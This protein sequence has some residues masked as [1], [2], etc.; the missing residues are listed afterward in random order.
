MDSPLVTILMPVYNADFFL[1]RAMDSIL[2]QTYSNIEF[3]IINDGSTDNSLSIIKS[4]SD[5]RIVL[6]ENEKNLGLIYSLNIG[7]QKARGKYVAR[8]DADDVSYKNRIQ[9]QLVFMENHSDVGIL[10]TFI[11]KEKKFELYAN[12]KLTSNEL[13]ARLIFNNIFNHPT[14]LFRNSF[15]KEQNISYNAEFK[16][17]EDYNLWLNTIPKT[18]FAILNESLLY[19]ENH[20]SQVSEIFN[21]E[22][23]INVNKSHRQFFTSLNLNF[24]GAEL[25]IHRRLFYQD[26]LYNKTFIAELENWLLKISESTSLQSLLTKEA[27]QKTTSVVWFEVC[28][29]FASKKI[30]THQRF[31]KSPLCN[32]KQLS[33]KSIL[34]F[35]LKSIFAFNSLP[36]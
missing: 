33:F 9:K 17:A 16:H 8:M 20:Q 27:L 15:L 26:Y 28:T 4:Y 18:D 25:E 12:P 31:Y 11:Q 2:E 1:K 5:N 14:I 22:Q 19:Y 7:L 36:L 30:K 29:H 6:I 13:K 32:T 10:G 3:L 35:N 24:S 34:L 23:K 21:A